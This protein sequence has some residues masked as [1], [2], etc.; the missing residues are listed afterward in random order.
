MLTHL[1]RFDGADG[2]S[3]LVHRHGLLAVERPRAKPER[4]EVV[5]SGVDRPDHAIQRPAESAIGWQVIG[6]SA[7]PHVVEELVPHPKESFSERILPGSLVHVGI[8]EPGNRD[9]EAKLRYQHSLVI[10]HGYPPVCT[11]SPSVCW[12]YASSRS[13]VPTPALVYARGRWPGYSLDV[14]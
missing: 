8:Y 6:Q 5:V 14:A 10:G 4:D 7:L 13:P 11:F 2:A 12:N 3:D 1:W 9:H